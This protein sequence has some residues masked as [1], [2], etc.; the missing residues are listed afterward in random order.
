ML[1]QRCTFP[2]PLIEVVKTWSVSPQ[3]W[4]RDR[5]RQRDSYTRDIPI[6]FISSTSALSP[7][8]EIDGRINGCMV[9]T[10]LVRVSRASED[11]SKTPLVLSLALALSTNPRIYW[12]KEVFFSFLPRVSSFI[13]SHIL[14]FSF[15]ALHACPS[16]GHSKYSKTS[17]RSLEIYFHLRGILRMN[18]TSRI[19]K[20]KASE[21]NREI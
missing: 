6:Q 17:P 13:Y 18:R 11:A 5:T 15:P 12:S 21:I 14:A 2:S 9:C 20:N 10:W 1:Y 8:G 7:R 19:D 3:S 4:N 16:G